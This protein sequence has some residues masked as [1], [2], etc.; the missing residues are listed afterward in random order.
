MAVYK[1]SVTAVFMQRTKL[2]PIDEFLLRSI[3]IG[4]SDAQ[5]ACEL[6]GLDTATVERHL[7]KLH[8]EEFIALSTNDGID[9]ICL[10]RKGQDCARSA[11]SNKMCEERLPVLFHGFAR[12]VIPNRELR[13]TPECKRDEMLILGTAKGRPTLDELTVADVRPIVRQLFQTRS[14]DSDLP[15]LLGIK[16]ISKLGPVM[17]E[18]G[19]L[20]I[21][22][23]YE[24]SQRHYSF[25]VEGEK[26][27]DYAQKFDAK[28]LLPKHFEFTEFKSM[29]EIA[30]E[31]LTES[32]IPDHDE[33]IHTVIRSNEILEQIEEL[34]AREAEIIE[35]SDGVSELSEPGP[36][37]KELAKL[38]SDLAE[39]NHRLNTARAVPLRTNG[40]DNLLTRSVDQC[41]KKLVV[42]SGTISSIAVEAF[43]RIAEKAILNRG[44]EVLIGYGMGGKD[45]QSDE[46]RARESFEI[47]KG[48]LDA[49]QRKFPNNVQVKDLGN[50][51]SKILLCD[52]QFVAV[53]SYNWLS[54]KP[55]GRGRHRG[56]HAIQL[57]HIEDVE[58]FANE[59]DF[60]FGAKTS[61]PPIPQQKQ[62]E[63]IKTSELVNERSSSVNQEGTGPLAGLV[64]KSKAPSSQHEV[65]ERYQLVRRI[66]GGG[67]AEAWEAL[68]PAGATVFLKRVP[69]DSQ[70]RAMIE[71]E[72][73][74][75]NKLYRIESEY[76]VSFVDWLC[77]ETHL[78]I[79]TEF[80]TEGD[81]K[82][83]VGETGMKPENVFEIAMQVANALHVLHSN[84][85]VHRDLKADNVLRF[86]KHWKLTDFGISKNLLR[87]GHQTVRGRGTPGY[88][89]PEQVLS[90]AAHPNADIYAYGK[91]LTFLL[92]G[93][94]DIDRVPPG[95]WQ[96]IILACTERNVDER[97][98]IDLLIYSLKQLAD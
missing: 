49:F 58:W 12:T 65:F 35:D 23:T 91:L 64:R 62:S 51:H 48:M 5:T 66:I 14:N 81:L 96:R 83:C 28:L 93:T 53:G 98:D 9:K 8:R 43:L 41:R 86:G 1:L 32:R 89:S 50:I 29:G 31:F 36:R 56:E 47:A 11:S 59:C 79:V 92:T 63:Q 26:R 95:E 15:E 75:Y 94:T 22:E 85:I 55:V 70:F 77:T 97:L 72:Q 17:Y 76:I 39:A 90:A 84:N 16:S 52:E 71:R 57:S 73:E 20:L 54:Y 74:I 67:M 34:T 7:I 40:C 37:T 61:P 6:L 30:S 13:T 19:I 87:E 10:T 60:L 24:H 18:P 46:Q 78:A 25:V 69:V 2:A 4:I 82:S 88:A 68:S 42:I 44:I 80:T 3:G 45:R 33:L 38:R 27:D 21:Y